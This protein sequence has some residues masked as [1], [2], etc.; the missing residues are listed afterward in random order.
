MKFCKNCSAALNDDVMIC[1]ECGVSQA[2]K[3]QAATTDVGV[4]KYSSNTDY[5]Q[6]PQ[7]QQQVYTPVPEG[8]NPGVPWLI[9]SIVMFVICCGNILAIPGLILAIMSMT[10]F[11][12]GNVE[13]AQNR[14]KIAKTLTFI[15]IALSIVITIIVAA[16]GFATSTLEGY[17]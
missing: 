5:S 3:T 4:S 2:Y 14:A 13:E 12:A 11:N 10:S 17:Y 1:P 6:E 8:K 9:V 15:A 7:Q 16:T